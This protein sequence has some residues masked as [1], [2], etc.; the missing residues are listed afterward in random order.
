MPF[1]PVVALSDIAPVTLAEGDVADAGTAGEASRQDHRHGMPSAY[2]PSAH[3]VSH[4]IGGA[5]MLFALFDDFLGNA[6]RPEWTFT[7]DYN[8]V[9]VTG[10]TGVLY[11]TTNGYYR[12]TTSGADNSNGAL[13]TS[14]KFINAGKNPV[15]E[16]RMANA[17]GGTPGSQGPEIWF[18]LLRT[19]ANNFIAYYNHCRLG[20]HFHT[21]AATVDTITTV[22]SYDSAMRT[23]K[24]EATA[25]QCKCYED[26]SLVATH[27]TNI[28]TG[29]GEVVLYAD[30][31]TPSA[32]NYDFD[33]IWVKQER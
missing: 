17:P 31:E 2:T 1:K 23:I 18:F 29:D 7:D 6:L 21:R 13:H 26:G 15:G 28:P 5:D 19:D 9:L 3:A 25:S 33:Y 27:T 20:R 22:G 16:C 4:V 32:D 24:I 8:G 14:M 11:E 30:S 10:A 12:I